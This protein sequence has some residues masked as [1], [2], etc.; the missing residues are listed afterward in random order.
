MNRSRTEP[1]RIAAARALLGWSEGDLAAAAGLDEGAVKDAEG[2]GTPSAGS[3][4]RILGALEKAGIVFLDEDGNG[5]GVRLA[6]PLARAEGL[7]PDQLNA[8]NDE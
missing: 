1:R 8:S 4:E 7:R 5:P 3:A 6:G 2:P